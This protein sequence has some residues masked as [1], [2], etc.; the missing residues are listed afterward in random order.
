[1]AI[2][3][4]KMMLDTAEKNDEKMRLEAELRA[5]TADKQTVFEAAKKTDELL[6]K[7]TEEERQI[8]EKLHQIASESIEKE[9][10]ERQAMTKQLADLRVEFE[11][12]R[13]E[14]DRLRQEMAALAEDENKGKSAYGQETEMEELETLR[15]KMFEQNETLKKLKERIHRITS[16]SRT[17]RKEMR[18]KEEDNMKLKRRIKCLED[19]IVTVQQVAAETQLRQLNELQSQTKETEELKETLTELLHQQQQ[20]ATEDHHHSGAYIK[21]AYL[22][23]DQL[24]IQCGPKKLSYCTLFI[25][26]LRRSILFHLQPVK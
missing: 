12:L 24:S 20:P 11:A 18:E 21:I 7:I 2:T 10:R 26:S 13:N 19:E 3:D 17:Q 9:Q 15:R 5:K 1:M 6:R 4:T 25:F 14:N 16:Y 22:I 8:K 23:A